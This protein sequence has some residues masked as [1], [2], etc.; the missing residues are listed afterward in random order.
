[1]GQ[2]K[3]DR[4]LE[5][6][7]FVLKDASGN[8]GAELAKGKLGPE[9]TLNDVSGHPSVTLVGGDAPFLTL[10][11][12]KGEKQINLSTASGEPAFTL[13][14]LGAGAATLSLGLGGPNLELWDRQGYSAILGRAGLATS[15]P[16]EIRQTSAASLVL[17]DKDKNV[18]WKAP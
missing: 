5:A 4:T 9:L 18:I 11:L 12:G 17:F 1:M 14:D 6:Q 2:A 7:R 16:G 10:T 15:K 3:S 8:V 13:T